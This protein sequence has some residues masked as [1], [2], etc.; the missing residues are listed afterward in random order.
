MKIFFYI[1]F[2]VIFVQ[3]ASAQLYVEKQTRHRFAQ[4]TIGLDY[5]RSFGGKTFFLN[6]SNELT[7]LTLNSLTVPRLIIGGTHFWGHADIYIAIPLGG[8]TQ[9][10]QSQTIR[11]QSGVE[12]VFKFYPYRIQHNRLRPFIGFSLA[13]NYYEQQNDLLEFG[14]GPNLN[15]TSFPLQTGITYNRGNHLLEGTVTWNYDQKESYYLNRNIEVDIEP[16]LGYVTLSYKYLFDTTISAEEDWESGETARVTELLARK[17]ELNRLFVGA[18]LSSAFW[19]SENSY[20]QSI[21]PYI[22]AYS[23]S[24]MPELSAGYY[25]HNP[26]INFSLTYRRYN[27]STTAYG[28][29]QQLKR[30]A[31]GAE[32]TKYLFDYQGFAPFIG[33]YF[34]REELRFEEFFEQSPTFRTE[35]KKWS[36]GLTF[37][38]DIRPNRIQSF[39]LRTNLRWFPSLTVDAPQGHDIAFNAIEFNFIQFIYFINR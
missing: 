22:E 27:T 9:Q 34:G 23:T 29:I 37:G 18:G 16:P 20:N 14:N 12:T 2:S 3:T 21:R 11:F 31:F 8:P 33:P 19:L 38:W 32:I 28:A 1:L 5:Q 7:P 25:L 17:K 39:L 15:H 10:E 26:D 24:I 4:M 13:P 36:Y 6:N 35:E 30:Q